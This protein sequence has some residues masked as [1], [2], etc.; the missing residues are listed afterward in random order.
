M[1]QSRREIKSR[2]T[3]FLKENFVEAFVDEE[4]IENKIESNNF[5]KHG[6]FLTHSVAQ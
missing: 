5:P 4:I 3:R 6:S 1:I 2:L